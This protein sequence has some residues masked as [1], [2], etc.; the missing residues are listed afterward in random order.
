[1]KR[2][3]SGQFAPGNSGRPK[4]S[5]NKIAQA[6]KAKIN[7]VLSRIEDDFLEGDLLALKP[8]ERVALYANLLEYVTPKLQRVEREPTDLEELLSMSKPERQASIQ[9]I[10]SQ[11]NG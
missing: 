11:L 2:N 9:E 10:K 3:Q 5:Q 4:G 1:M 6:R 8:R 7:E